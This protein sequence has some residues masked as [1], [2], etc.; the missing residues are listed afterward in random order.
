MLLFPYSEIS[1]TKKYEIDNMD[2]CSCAKHLLRNGKDRIFGTVYYEPE[3]IIHK[4][5]LTTDKHGQVR[6]SKYWNQGRAGSILTN[7]P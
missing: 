3:E 2:L 4:I 6:T 5:T 1:I 7:H